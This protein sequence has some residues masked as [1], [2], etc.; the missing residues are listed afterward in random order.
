MGAQS[1]AIIVAHLVAGNLDGGA[2]RGAYWLHQ[3]LRERG[4]KST[5]LYSGS[6][7]SNDPS[8]ASLADTPAKA[9]A[10]ALT[11]RFWSLPTLLYRK[12]KPESFSVGM[13]G[14]DFAAHPLYR[15]ANVVHLHWISGLVSMKSLRRIDKP[16]V[17]TLRDM[18]PLTGGCH[19]SLACDRY[20]VGCG[21]CPLLGSGS[22]NDLSRFVFERKRASLPAQLQVVGIS[23]WLSERARESPVFAGRTV[24]TIS[25]NVSTRVFFPIDKQ[26]ARQNFALGESARIVL[27]GAQTLSPAYK[28]FD[29]FVS[30]LAVLDVRA[31]HFL[32]FGAVS[33][34]ALNRLGINYTS[35]GF[36]ADEAELREVYSAADVFVAPSRSEAFGKTLAEA[37]ACQTPVVCFDTSGPKDIVEHKISG[38]R[39]RPF[40]A[41]D[42]AAGIRWVLGQPEAAYKAMCRQARER[43]QTRFDS[44]VIAGEYLKLYGE[45]LGALK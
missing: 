45:M 32:F 2:A 41:S 20:K 15:S 37:M 18:W 5:V 12:R 1:E 39:A 44:R 34:A 19:Y 33:K 3:A 17:W 24:R 29:L 27:V 10:A 43:V 9:I 31:L 7:R 30:A 28:G 4:V 8:V 35:L 42:L 6:G 16:V 25:N 36:I 13:A 22:R 38:Y 26:A 40:D 11:R 23:E 21:R 14:I